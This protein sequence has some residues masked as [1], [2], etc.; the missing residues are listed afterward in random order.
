MLQS[1]KVKF[2]WFSSSEKAPSRARNNARTDSGITA[3]SPS[4]GLASARSAISAP[5]AALAPSTGRRRSSTSNDAGDRGRQLVG[6]ARGVLAKIRRPQRVAEEPPHLAGRGPVVVAVDGDGEGDAG[7]SYQR[8]GECTGAAAAGK[9]DD[10]QRRGVGGSMGH[11]Q[12]W[13]RPS[14][15]RGGLMNLRNVSRNLSSSAGFPHFANHVHRLVLRLV[16]GA[17]LQFGQQADR[18][19][20]HACENQQ[21]AKE[22]QRPVG[23]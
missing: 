1:S 6:E 7:R 18:H 10:S 4:S 9:Q 20:L 23:Q 16:V 13:H 3:T 11:D 15:Q 22:Q 17:G 8:R 12:L 19:Q 2:R 21:H 5:S 14:Q